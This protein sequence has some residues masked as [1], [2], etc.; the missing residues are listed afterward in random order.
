[1]KK[2]VLN[3]GFV[4]LVEFMGG[5]LQVINSAGVSFNRIQKELKPGDDKRIHRM[6]RL[7]HG[8][9]FESSVFTFHVKAPIFVIREW[10]RHRIASYNEISGR[11]VE[12]ANEM[13][14]PDAE[15]VRCQI[16]KAS[17]S[18][19]ETIPLR[20]AEDIIAD[21]RRSHND[22]YKTYQTL[23]A[24][25]CAKEVARMV[26]PLSIYSEFY[27]TI[28]ARSLM[29]FISLRSAPAALLEIQAY[30]NVISNMFEKKMPF[31]YEG[32]ILNNKV[33]P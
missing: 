28:N 20:I 3:F 18:K 21:M 8:T 30:A 32:F 17:E 2:T 5:D 29:N 9:P 4:E 23:L 33:A 19:F 31:T 10:Q 7:R 1:M 24:L 26:L 25:G 27:F 6:V 22:A 13:Y 11:Y 12:L 15:F 14:I 16:G